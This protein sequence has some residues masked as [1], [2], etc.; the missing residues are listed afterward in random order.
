MG[1]KHF[2]IFM[3][4][5]FNQHMHKMRKGQNFEDI[6]VD[7]DNFMI[8]MN[9]VFHNSAQKI[10][11]YGNFKPKSRLLQFNKHKHKGLQTQ[12]K[13]FEDICETIDKLFKIVNPKKRLILC[14]DGPAPLAKQCQQRQRRF[15]SAMEQADDAPFNSNCITPGTK[16]MDYLS[17]YIDWYIR[18]KI[19]EDPFWRKVQIIFSNEKAPGEGEHKCFLVKTPIL[20]WNGMTKAVED[21]KVGDQVIGDDGTP[22]TVTNLVSGYDEMFEIIQTNA[23][24][25][26]VNKHHILSLQIAKHK[27]IYWNK[28]DRAW[29]VGWYD[30]TNNRYRHKQFSALREREEMSTK[31]TD[32]DKTCEE[33]NYTNHIKNNH[34][35]IRFIVQTTKEEAL[36]KAKSFLKTIDD[37]NVLDISVADYL[38]LSKNTQS[39]LYGFRCSGVEWSNQEVNIDPYLLGL[40]LMDGVST[41]PTICSMDDEIIQ[42]LTKYYNKYIK[43]RICDPKQ[44]K[45]Y[46]VSL[47]KKYNLIQNKHIPRE[48]L[49]NDRK[50][51]LELLAGII[52]TDVNVTKEGRLIRISQC[53]KYKQLVDDI[54]Y[55]ARSLG[56]CVNVIIADVTHIYNEKKNKGECYQI[57]ISGNLNDIPTLIARK[58]CSPLLTSGENGSDKLRTSIEVKP[59]GRDQYYGFNTDGNHR[60]LLGDFTVTHNCIQF[61]RYYG[62][63][64]ETFCING[65]DADL[66]MLALGTHMPN[67]YIL[68]EDLYDHNNEFFCVDVGQIRGELAEQLRWEENKHKFDPT[69]AINDF[70]FLCFMVGNDFLPHIPSIEIMEHGIELILEV[71]RETGTAYGHITRSVRGRVQFLPKPLGVFL[72]TIGQHEKT[73]FENK[74]YKKES[75]F[76]DRLLESCA[77]QTSEGKWVV[78]INKYKTDYHIASFPVG[79]DEEKLCHE[80]FEGMQWVLSYYTRGVPNW[81]WHFAY[82]YAPCASTLAK[83]SDTFKFPCYG[84]TIPSTP[85]QQLLCVLPP[86]S[87][88]LLPEPLCRLLI[89][90]KSPLKKHCPD[91]FKIDLSGKRKEW[92]GIVILPMV[93]FNLVRECYLNSLN[94]IDN[95]EL[96]R[97]I[98]G[99]SFVYEYIPGLPGIFRSYY[100]NIDRC[101]VRLVLIDL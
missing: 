18:K 3:K 32:K 5:H 51:R 67:F 20:L 91:N 38:K 55:L 98:T 84:R 44:K 53:L 78:D 49:V 68:R 94:Q 73:N 82:H 65:L 90:E 13:L 21:I 34:N 100:G 42:F 89:D 35:N 93:D 74:L 101:H 96:K 19:N 75:F 22:R 66:F 79:I 57:T 37:D 62:N 72:G 17:K 26:T 12:V 61:I 2:N 46:I 85:F 33:Y 77:I 63:R 50:T 71:Y 43:Y 6:R 80:Y 70:I 97:N 64:D 95:K 41:Q 76:P 9:G 69:A 16:F 28:K 30:R 31:M 45:S 99:R 11:E 15:R 23:D 10:Y 58:K 1:I 40:W 83:Y 60:F 48:Y 27:H 29:I 8:D 86:K 14:V 24:N 56:F 36:E 88:D 47:L 87:A 54:V 39:K 59:V 7:V 92:E 4:K 52:D 81:K 25:Y